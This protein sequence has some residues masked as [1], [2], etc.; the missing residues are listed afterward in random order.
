MAGKYEVATGVWLH[1]PQR[2]KGRSPKL[3]R[4]WEGPYVVVKQIN[5]VVVQIK[6]GPQAK[7]KVVHINRLKPYTGGE[8]FGWFAEKGSTGSRTSRHLDV[9]K[10]ENL[11]PT[12]HHFI[13][14]RVASVV[15][16]FESGN[17]FTCCKHRGVACQTNVISVVVLRRRKVHRLAFQ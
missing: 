8:Y 12:R 1:N 15:G 9:E 3:S 14:D 13:F 16:T 7:P 5:D 17:N 10:L 11:P 2:K 4:N 6:K